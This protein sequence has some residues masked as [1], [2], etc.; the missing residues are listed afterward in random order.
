M[1]EMTKKRTEQQE[2]MIKKLQQQVLEIPGLAKRIQVLD[3]KFDSIQG[4]NSKKFESQLERIQQ[5]KVYLETRIEAAMALEAKFDQNKSDLMSVQDTMLRTKTDI[6][7]QVADMRSDNQ[8]QAT[9]NENLETRMDQVLADA[10]FWLEKY[11]AAYKENDAK[12]GSMQGEFNGRLDSI[13]YQLKQRVTVDD[14]K[15]NFNKL[16]DML[17][18]KFRQVEDNKH[19]L[20]D[21]INY[22]KHF[23]PLQMQ[24]IIGENM[25]NLEAA[26]RDQSYVQYQQ[27]HYNK[28]LTDLQA[29][30]DAA[31]GEPDR[32]MMAHLDELDNR[33]LKSTGW[34][35]VPLDN[36]EHD[37]VTPLLNLYLEDIQ[38]RIKRHD[39][40]DAGFATGLRKC[41][42][43]ADTED[44]VNLQY[45][46]I[47]N[48][49]EAAD[50]KEHQLELKRV[51]DEHNRKVRRLVRE[52]IDF[53][54]SKG[55][56]RQNSYLPQLEEFGDIDDADA[57]KFNF[58]K[59]RK[60]LNPMKPREIYNTK[61]ED[62]MQHRLEKDIMAASVSD[63]MG[64]TGF[65]QNKAR[66][67]DQSFKRRTNQSGFAP[68]GKSSIQVDGQP[69]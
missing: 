26:M 17:N 30:Q 38:T 27:K 53:K 67:T 18:I 54:K 50:H 12:I 32:E 66:K 61:V 23:Y 15:K 29:T 55:F 56:K 25:M 10:K 3:Q 14:M 57:L 19:A 68:S 42:R 22:Q 44:L 5:V 36:V 4:N 24:A 62:V 64:A 33:Q 48:L 21:M 65:K 46:K 69:A 52:K 60:S 11:T 8:K 20:R 63:S 39:A 43:L 47:V 6:S 2:Q 51:R 45:Q 16:T 9:R 34:I 41:V 35:T 59:M 37:F 28:L 1:A 49:K 40:E 13:H 7:Q 31:K 58:A